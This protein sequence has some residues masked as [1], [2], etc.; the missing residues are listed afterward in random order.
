ML[1]MDKIIVPL[2]WPGHWCL[3]VIDI[4]NRSFEYFDSLLG[5]NRVCL[6]NLRKWLVDEVK[7]KKGE[8]FDLSGWKDIWWKE[9][10]KQTNS[11]DCGVFVCMYAECISRGEWPF[12]FSQSDVGHFRK[13]MAY[14]LVHKSM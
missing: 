10:P 8:H 12:T 13:K 11:S 14:Q 1:K 5:E 6:Q 3:A 9:I 7:D 4:K 2:N